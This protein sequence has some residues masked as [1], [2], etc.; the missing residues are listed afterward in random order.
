MILVPTFRFANLAMF[1]RAPSDGSDV[2]T[3]VLATYDGSFGLTRIGS[4]GST[5]A[6]PDL[7]M[8]PNVIDVVP[9]LEATVRTLTASTDARVLVTSDRL[10][11]YR[12]CIPTESPVR[13]RFVELGTI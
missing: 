13:I 12:S 5:C 9:G 4:T 11:L 8:A 3:V 1:Q 10:R 6:A 7:A 2:K